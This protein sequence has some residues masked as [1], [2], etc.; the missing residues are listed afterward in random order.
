[1]TNLVCGIQDSLVLYSFDTQ[2]HSETIPGTIR[3]LS[4]DDICMDHSALADFFL[5]SFLR[6]S[7]N[8][9]QEARRVAGGEELIG[10]V[11]TVAAPAER[12]G[13]GEFEVERGRLSVCGCRRYR[14]IESASASDSHLVLD[15][16]KRKKKKRGKRVNERR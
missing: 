7:L 3:G 8:R 6:S 2:Y 10:V 5:A 12:F 15:S 9:A 4:Q 16:Q 1:M 13:G 14:A 11:P